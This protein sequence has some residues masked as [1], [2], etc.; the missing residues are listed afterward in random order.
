MLDS[1]MHVKR[2][3]LVTV[4]F[5]S[6][7]FLIDPVVA[8]SDSTTLS[9]SGSSTHTIGDWEP[10]LT[11]LRIE[12]STALVIEGSSTITWSVNKDFISPGESVNLNV[13][14]VN[15]NY[16]P[17]L[18]I[19]VKIVKKSTSAIIVDKTLELPFPSAP[20]PGSLSSPKLSVPIIPFE[21]IG[22]PAE[23]SLQA[24]LY[25]DSIF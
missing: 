21:L 24:Q 22:V 19:H 25:L 17:S 10:W 23:L 20:L 4:L 5:L 15:A 6:S 16:V 18:L 3:F 9:F 14:L 11:G 8:S 13:A 7:F 1:S 12:L 2:Y